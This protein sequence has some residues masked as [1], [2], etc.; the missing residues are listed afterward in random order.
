[1]LTN[2]KRSAE[3]MQKD[4]MSQKIVQILTFPAVDVRRSTFLNKPG[5]AEGGVFVKVSPK[6]VSKG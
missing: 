1:M 2:Q 4:F 5:G 6:L 3:Q